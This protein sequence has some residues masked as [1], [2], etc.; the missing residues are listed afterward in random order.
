MCEEPL[1]FQTTNL[2][3]SDTTHD[4]KGHT[5]VNSKSK[6]GGLPANWMYHLGCL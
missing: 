5:L 3:K 1:K 2:H 4:D 6:L